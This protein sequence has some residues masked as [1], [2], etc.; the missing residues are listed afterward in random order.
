MALSVF[1]ENG[2]TKI[3]SDLPKRKSTARKDEGKRNRDGKIFI[4][5]APTFFSGMIIFFSHL[6]G[7]YELFAYKL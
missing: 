3:R 7:M 5:P 2:F 4:F 6:L 1:P